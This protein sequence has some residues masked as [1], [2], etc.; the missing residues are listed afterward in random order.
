[1]KGKYITTSLLLAIMASE[2]AAH[3]INVPEIKANTGGHA[4][5]W[6]KGLPTGKELVARL[7]GR[8]ELKFS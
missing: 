6:S 5:L 1:M 4:F 3:S 7:K 2:K 8:D